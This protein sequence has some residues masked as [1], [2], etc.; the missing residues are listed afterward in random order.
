VERRYYDASSLER[1]LLWFE[2]TYAMTSRDF[3]ESKRPPA[4]SRAYR[5]FT[6]TSGRAVIAT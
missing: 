3:Y 4:T 2:R 6:A 1:V 5:A